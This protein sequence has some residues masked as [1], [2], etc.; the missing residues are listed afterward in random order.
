MHQQGNYG[1]L[2]PA[3]AKAQYQTLPQTPTLHTYIPLVLDS[4]LLG[5]LDQLA[6]SSSSSSALFHLQFDRACTYCIWLDRVPQTD[7]A[8]RVSGGLKMPH[9]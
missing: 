1:S 8:S 5:A 7:E 3:E 6:Q 2:H 9:N 4:D